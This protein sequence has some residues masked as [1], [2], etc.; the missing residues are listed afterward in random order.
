MANIPQPWAGD[1]AQRSTR[2]APLTQGDPDLG[3]GWEW[4]RCARCAT[5]GVCTPN[6]DFYTR[7]GAERGPLFCERC[8]TMKTEPPSQSH[9]EP[10]P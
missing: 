10:Q 3:T 7:P 4:C 1:W 8:I 5:V 9:S 2:A 6:N